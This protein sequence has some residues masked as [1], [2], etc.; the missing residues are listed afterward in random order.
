[1]IEKTNFETN[2]KKLC[3]N[4]GITLG[5]LCKKLN[6]KYP[7]LHNA[8]IGKTKLNPTIANKLTTHFNC[9]YEELIGGDK[10]RPITVEKVFSHNDTFESYSLANKETY[11]SLD[12]KDILELVFDGKAVINNGNQVIMCIAK[13]LMIQ[14]TWDSKLS[15]KYNIKRL[16]KYQKALEVSALD[17]D[18]EAIDDNCYRQNNETENLPF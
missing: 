16:Q 10:V 8:A 17:N 2:L 1:M 5:N 9:T 13:G 15:I 6:I 3:K 4:N 11:L 14:Y 7:T 12:T 18:N